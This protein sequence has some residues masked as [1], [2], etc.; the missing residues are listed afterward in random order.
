MSNKPKGSKA[1]EKEL[2]PEE[3]IHQSLI[4]EA[5]L[6]KISRST[7]L[8]IR[9]AGENRKVISLIMQWEESFMQKASAL[10]AYALQYKGLNKKYQALLKKNES[11]NG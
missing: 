9:E 1:K 3:Q 10:N 4:N 5:D 11:K 8:A 6:K 7:S 2:T